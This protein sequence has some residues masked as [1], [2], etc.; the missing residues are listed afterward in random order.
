MA[1]PPTWEQYWQLMGMWLRLRSHALSSERI[2][3]ERV[4]GM[5]VRRFDMIWRPMDPFR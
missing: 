5:I 3:V 2:T 4:L 1:L